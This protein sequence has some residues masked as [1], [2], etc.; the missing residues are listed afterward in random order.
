MGRGRVIFHIDMNC[1]FAAVEMAY[2]ESL[3]GKPIAV[4]GNYDEQLRSACLW[5]ENDDAGLASEKTLP[6][7]N[8][9]QTEPRPLPRCFRGAFQFTLYVHA[10]RAE[11]LDR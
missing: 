9:R 2:D 7:F 11:S 1:F 3:R 8:D 10:F 4:A 5:G 6:A